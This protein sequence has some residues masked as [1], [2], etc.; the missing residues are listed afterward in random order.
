MIAA[1]RERR[2]RVLPLPEEY[3]AACTFHD[4]AEAYRK[5]FYP[6]ARLGRDNEVVF[7]TRDYF[8]ILRWL[9]FM[10]R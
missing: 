10:T 4:P 9:G 7:E 8:E 5:Q 6:G 1:L 3:V 2:G